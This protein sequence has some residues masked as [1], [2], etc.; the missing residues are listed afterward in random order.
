MRRCEPNVLMH[1]NNRISTKQNITTTTIKYWLWFRWL[2]F[3]LI[4]LYMTGIVNF[5]FI[6]LFFFSLCVAIV[7]S[8]RTYRLWAFFFEHPIYFTEFPIK[9][10]FAHFSCIQFFFSVFQLTCRTQSNTRMCLH[11]KIKFKTWCNFKKLCF[12]FFSFFGSPL[13]WNLIVLRIAFVFH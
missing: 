6:I 9:T 11:H 13:D 4:S 3:E 5:S 7:I 12:L 8:T 1:E 2:F 10:Y